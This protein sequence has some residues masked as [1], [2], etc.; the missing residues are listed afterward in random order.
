VGGD[1]RDSVRRAER[2]K[3][4]REERGSGVEISV[5]DMFSRRVRGEV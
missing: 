4:R 2:L 5:V 1:W 3:R